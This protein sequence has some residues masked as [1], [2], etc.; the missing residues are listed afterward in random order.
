MG[1]KDFRNFDT[2]KGSYFEI[3][4]NT[5]NSIVENISPQLKIE[6]EEENE[7]LDNK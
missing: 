2:H 3:D 5:F 7:V 4:K 6:K 1:F